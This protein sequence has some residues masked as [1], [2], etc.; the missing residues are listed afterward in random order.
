MV[1]I[2]FSLL[3]SSLATTTAT[4][5]LQGLIAFGQLAERSETVRA[6]LVQ[7]SRDEFGELFVF[8]CAVDG[9]CVGW[10]GCVD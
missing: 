8:T 10:D 4:V 9:K 7:D 3:V 1:I 5:L 6:E 2:V